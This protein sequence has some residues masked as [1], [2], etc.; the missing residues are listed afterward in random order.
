MIAFKP[1]V[2]LCLRA[3]SVS[4]NKM[5]DLFLPAS[6]RLS[7]ETELLS[8][9]SPVTCS[10][11]SN[12]LLLYPR[13]VA[14]TILVPSSGVLSGPILSSPVSFMCVVPPHNIKSFF[15]FFFL[16]PLNET[17]T[18]LTPLPWRLILL[19]FLLHPHVE[20]ISNRTVYW[21]SLLSSPKSALLLWKAVILQLVG[22]PYRQPQCMREKY[23]VIVRVHKEIMGS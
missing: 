14:V 12:R 10:P 21:A 3:Y 23:C 16:T 13:T 9:I 2:S 18:T 11:S 15:F 1:D 17:H 4:A 8:S 20:E 7:R 6:C 5:S 19:V 22:S